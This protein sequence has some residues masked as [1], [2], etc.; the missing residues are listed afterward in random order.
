MVCCQREP[1]DTRLHFAIGNFLQQIKSRPPTFDGLVDQDGEGFPRIHVVY[2]RYG[3]LHSRWMDKRL[4]PTSG[5]SQIICAMFVHTIDV[6]L[7]EKEKNDNKNNKKEATGE[8][9]RDER[10]TNQERW[11]K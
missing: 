11:A 3:F 6:I 5:K 7:G 10:L 9:Q 1:R 8:D 4:L 2:P